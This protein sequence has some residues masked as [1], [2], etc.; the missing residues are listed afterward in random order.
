MHVSVG[1]S[2]K[3]NSGR[4]FGPPTAM[5]P[6]GGVCVCVFHP[7]LTLVQREPHWGGCPPSINPPPRPPQ[8]SS[9]PTQSPHTPLKRAP[10]TPSPSPPPPYPGT[11]LLPPFCPP[12]NFWT[13]PCPQSPPRSHDLA[14][15]PLFIGAAATQNRDNRV[16]FCGG[17]GGGGEGEEGTTPHLPLPP[18]KLQTPPPPCGDTKTPHMGAAASLVAPRRWEGGCFPGG[19]PFHLTPPPCP[20]PNF[21]GGSPMGVGGGE[22]GTLGHGD[23]TGWRS[24][25]RPSASGS[26]GQ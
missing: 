14:T 18:P 22:G 13:P 11:P 10:F 19:V 2:R 6:L 8:S 9:Q 20:S 23:I 15:A 1:W 5:T 12:P 4:P 16:F 25:R 21:L 26:S 24:A 3:W 17:R 7:P